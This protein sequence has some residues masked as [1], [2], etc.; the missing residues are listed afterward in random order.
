MMIKQ[1]SNNRKR[2][3]LALGGGVV[4]GMAHIGVLSVL[5]EAGIPID[6]IAGSSAGSVVGAIYA[7]GGGA[8]YLLGL[9]ISLR[10]W[11][12][13]RLVWPRRAFLSF[14][15]LGD[16][17]VRE[18]GDVRFSDLKTPFTAVAADLN[19]GEPIYLSEGR[20]APAVVASCSVPGIFEPAE[21]GGRI[22]GDGC[23]AET[24]PVKILRQMGA[25]YVIGVDIFSASF[26][27]HWGPIGMG[28]NAL[29]ILLRRSGGGIADADCL[30][31]PNLK[32]K[33]YLRFSK[34]EELFALGRDAGIEK[35]ERLRSDLQLGVL[36]AVTPTLEL[37]TSSPVFDENQEHNQ[38]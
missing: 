12:L 28:F 20:L 9:A 23:L 6:F 18:L 36:D 5:E 8:E 35:L 33:T 38:P 22:L 17:L 29:E 1:E 2:V 16:W 26:R 24:L 30:I 13:I 7:T 25:D 4:R 10:W 21:I 37:L 11:R 34:K 14:Q 19:S 3:G 31:V 27:T 15:P 32:G